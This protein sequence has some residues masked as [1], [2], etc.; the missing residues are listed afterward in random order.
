MTTI[1]PEKPE[2]EAFLFALYSST[3]QEEL[4]AWGW[5]QEA[6]RAF[7]TM[8][9]K[10]SQNY[11]TAFPNAEFNIV[12][13]DGIDAGRVILNRAPHELRIVDIALLPQYRNAGV[14]TALL[15]QILEE[16]IATKKTVRLTLRKGN[17]A[18]RLYQRIGF[19]RI[20]E[21][22]MHLEMECHPKRS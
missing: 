12:I 7:L 6:R 14:G 22:E 3:R 21:T 15:H 5:P 13:L 9:F 10:A 20:A 2:D 18:A 1:R 8:Q 19:G 16:A 4:D 17:R 11:R